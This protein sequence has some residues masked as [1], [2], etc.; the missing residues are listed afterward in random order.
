MSHHGPMLTTFTVYILGHT[1]RVTHTVHLVLVLILQTPLLG[2]STTQENLTENHPL[3]A[4]LPSAETIISLTH[5]FYPQCIP[6]V[7]F[8]LCDAFRDAFRAEPFDLCPKKFLRI[9]LI[10]VQIF[11]LYCFWGYPFHLYFCDAQYILVVLL[12]PFYSLSINS[13]YFSCLCHAVLHSISQWLL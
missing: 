7:C 6:D 5:Y 8:D 9:C 3:A 2:Q 4:L 11:A 13:L 1:V 10:N 12:L